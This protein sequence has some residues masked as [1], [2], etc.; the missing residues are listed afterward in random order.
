MIILS[1]LIAWLGTAAFAAL[2]GAVGTAI[3]ALFVGVGAAVGGPLGP[4]I[5]SSIWPV[6]GQPIVLWILDH[7][8]DIISMFYNISRKKVGMAYLNALDAIP[9]FEIILDFFVKQLLKINTKLE[10]I[11]PVTGNLKSISQIANN[12]VETILENPNSL[13]NI[14]S[15]YTLLVKKNLRKLPQLKN[16][17]EDDIVK[18][19]RIADELYTNAKSTFDCILDKPNVADGIK[20]ADFNDL[21]S[22]FNN[23]QIASLI[24][25]YVSGTKKSTP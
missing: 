3:G 21:S 11:Y 25:N 13:L 4:V 14:K 15:V 19:E 2:G 8:I 24:Q 10:K 20:L 22:C 18:Y 16:V 1:K 23:F 17:P 9:Y 5:T 12:V 7:Y 6:I